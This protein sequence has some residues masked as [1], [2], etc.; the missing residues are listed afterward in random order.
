MKY[1]KNPTPVLYKDVAFKSKLE[2]CW[3][4]YFDLQGWGWEYE[5]RNRTKRCWLP[6]FWLQIN[7]MLGVLVEVKPNREFFKVEKYHKALDSFTFVMLLTTHPRTA[8][9]I[10]NKCITPREF[11][12]EEDKAS[13]V[14][15]LFV[16]HANWALANEEIYQYGKI[17]QNKNRYNRC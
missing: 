5:P 3:A 6:D 14:D 11:V 15:S 8:E 10:S 2:A 4:V 9:Y 7:P 12:K 17:I 1:T 13:C 16:N